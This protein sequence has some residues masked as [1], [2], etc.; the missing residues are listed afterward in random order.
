M[1]EDLKK[2]IKRILALA[3]VILIILCLVGMLINAIIGGPANYTLLF[4]FLLI[5]VPALIYIFIH[6]SNI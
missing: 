4:L 2:K 5:V 3:G 6:F 1:N